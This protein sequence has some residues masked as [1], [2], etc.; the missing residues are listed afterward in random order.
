MAVI[1]C[2]SAT[3]IAQDGTSKRTV[4]TLMLE[5][6]TYPLKHA[7]AYETTSDNEQAIAVVLS[8]PAIS[9]EKLKEAKETEKGGND[10][11]FQR[12]FLRLVFSNTGALK[13]WS[14]AAG[15]T[16]LGRRSGTATGELKLQ[17][18][19]VIGKA[20]QPLETDGMFPSG[21]D[22]QF[23]VALLK[24]GES[25]PP[26]T[27]KKR[28]PAANVKPTVTGTFK[29]NG[30]DAKL[31]SV[32][33]R[34]GEPFGGKPGIVL[35]FTEKDH[36]KDK[37]PDFNAAFGKFGSALIISLHEDGGIYG[38]QVMHS[39]HQK[40]GFSSIGN[41][42]ATDITYADGKVEGE[43]T[44]H[45][46]VDTFGEKWEVNLKFVAPL[47]EIPKEFQIA[48]SKKPGDD[49][50]DDAEITRLTTNLS[51]KAAPGPAKDK[52]NVKDLA[53]T[54]DAAEFEYKQLVEQLSFKSKANVKSVC[55]ELA[56][57]LKAQGWTKEG[58]DLI[59]P[60]SSILKRKRGDA[61]LTIFVKP[62]SGGSKVQMMTE[63]LAWEEK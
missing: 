39:A 9:S 40:Q 24:A 6:K 11:D 31:T 51:E 13:H 16:M 22:A 60:A 43:L 5:K 49:A 7:L 44:T 55:A 27:V 41:I 4:G 57:N 50:T 3:V 48:D 38:C 28:G 1:V 34:W 19:R 17:E 32:S 61:E 63:G 36:S 30:K 42:E 25:L 15:G 35:V 2:A 47:G 59:T 21:F 53:L 29:G 18:G 20:S 26:S 14:A 58:S 46:E 33:A 62:E 12:P 8:G 54:K 52:L 23:D 10:P 45:G 56:A 37:K